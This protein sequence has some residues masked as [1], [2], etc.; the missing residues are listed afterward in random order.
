M[1]ARNTRKYIFRAYS[2]IITAHILPLVGRK[3]MFLIMG[4][5]QHCPTHYKKRAA[6]TIFPD[7]DGKYIYAKGKFV[8]PDGMCIAIFLF[9]DSKQ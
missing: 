9:R 6:T 4:P 3:I 5:A 2:S 1:R 8:E 7:E